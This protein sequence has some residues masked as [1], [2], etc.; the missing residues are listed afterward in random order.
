MAAA[1]H[2]AGA[3]ASSVV[4]A[5]AYHCRTMLDPAIE[6][7]ASL[8]LYA[9]HA[10]LCPDES[11][12]ERRLTAAGGRA[13][14]V[15]VTHFFGRMVPLERLRALCD[16]HDCRLVEDCSHCLVGLDGRPW[17]R[18]AAAVSGDY[19]VASPYKFHPI[20]DGGTVWSARPL[21]LPRPRPASWVRD[22][23]AALRTLLSGRPANRGE[24][25]LPPP[26][27]L[28][29]S[30]AECGEDRT[31]DGVRSPSPGFDARW[32]GRAGLRWSRRRWAEADLGAVAEARRANARLW[33][34]FLSTLQ[35][36]APLWPALADDEVPY[37]VPACLAGRPLA[38]RRLKRLGMPLGRWDDMV[39]AEC[40]TAASHRLSLVHLPCHQDLSAPEMAWMQ[41][42]LRAATRQ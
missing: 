6:A 21:R 9:V 29:V 41:D 4:L 38:F 37:M 23:A 24:N 8:S 15:I 19:V 25:G 39:V 34:H 16:R 17:H 31:I 42:C 18:P 40:E 3:D 36:V 28:T 35:G 1:L 27:G 13:R 30:D 14:A 32:L 10:D 7:G 22:A 26:H 5:P 12:I 20:P 33:L 11:D 2:D